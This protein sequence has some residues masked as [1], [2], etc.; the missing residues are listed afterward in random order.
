MMLEMKHILQTIVVVLGFCLLSLQGKSQTYQLQIDSIVGIPD[1]IQ[2]G[3]EVTFYMI[4]SM[5]TPLFYQGDVFV[6]LEYG[7]QFYEVDSSM[8]ASTFLSPSAPNTI[9][10]THIFTTDNDLSIG[11]NVVVVWPR[12]GDGVEPPQTVVNPETIVVHIVEPNGIDDHSRVRQR[13]LFYPNP[14]QNTVRLKNDLHSELSTVKIR[15]AFGRTVKM[16]QSVVEMNVSDLPDGIY[17]VEA[18]TKDGIL[19]ADKLVISR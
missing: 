14:A 9:Q 13:K 4:V 12:I 15:D 2:N 5:N 11:D 19:L 1:T 8:N 16:T 10:A 6:E 7:G 3:Q 17:F 18:Q